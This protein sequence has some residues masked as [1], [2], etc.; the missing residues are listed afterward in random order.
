MNG[1]PVTRQLLAAVVCAAMVS[2]AAGEDLNSILQ[3]LGGRDARQAQ[4]A[5]QQAQRAAQ[6][7]NRA[8]ER[9]DREDACARI[10]AW[11]ANIDSLPPEVLAASLRWG[12]PTGHGRRG[13]GGAASPL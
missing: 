1:L 5:A 13:A 11:L 12:R 10:S 4:R 3:Q 9:Q 2:G 7:A 6:Q 8:A